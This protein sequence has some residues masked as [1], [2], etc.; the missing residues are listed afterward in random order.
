MLGL[1]DHLETAQQKIRLFDSLTVFER[2]PLS[3]EG[4]T[5]ILLALKR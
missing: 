5:G 4:Y 1:Q 2:M 3:N